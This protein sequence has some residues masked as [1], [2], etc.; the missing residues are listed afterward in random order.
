MTSAAPAPAAATNV[1]IESGRLKWNA[2]SGRSVVYYFADLTK[3]GMVHV[4]TKD[5]ETAI[6]APGFYCVS[7]LNADNKESEVS[8]TVEL[9]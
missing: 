1:R 3:E 5:G 2:S 7:T 6:T 4:I 9:K 8:A